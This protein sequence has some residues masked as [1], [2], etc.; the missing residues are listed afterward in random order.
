MS[1]ALLVAT[2]LLAPIVP[3]QTPRPP[4]PQVE[5]KKLRGAFAAALL[6]PGERGKVLALGKALESKFSRES[7]LAALAEGPLPAKG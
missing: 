1:R 3:A 4:V 6:D 5:A 2:A 7:L